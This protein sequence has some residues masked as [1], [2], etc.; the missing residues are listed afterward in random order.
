RVRPV[1][2]VRVRIQGEGARGQ[3][4]EILE[5]GAMNTEDDGRRRNRLCKHDGCSCGEFGT[6]WALCSTP[7]KS[8]MTGPRG[9]IVGGSLGKRGCADG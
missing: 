5:Q 3:Q 2:K 8:G 6:S 7:A 4:I 9:Q 1:E